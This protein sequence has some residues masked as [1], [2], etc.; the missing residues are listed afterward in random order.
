MAKTS[1]PKLSLVQTAQNAPTPPPRAGVLRELPTDEEPTEAASVVF[2]A[3]TESLHRNMLAARDLAELFTERDE[4]DRAARCAETEI[5]AA[6]ALADTWQRV[7]LFDRLSESANAVDPVSAA[8]AAARADAASAIAQA[9]AAVVGPA[10]APS[11]N[12]AGVIGGPE[13]G[14]DDT[15]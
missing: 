6:K 3:V 11:V 2:W 8:E 7:G 15:E 4:P 12:A 9:L 5:R 14:D 1:P 10:G 13:G